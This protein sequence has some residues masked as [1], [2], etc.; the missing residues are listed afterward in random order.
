MQLKGG[1]TPADSMDM[2]APRAPRPS[3]RCIPVPV[4]ALL[5]ATIA[6]LGVTSTTAAAQQAPA[7][8][9]SLEE[10]L[11]VR[12]VAAA[13]REQ[14][15]FDSPRSISVVTADDLRRRNYRSTPEAL[16]EVAGVM[17]QQTN[18]GGGSPI[19]RGLIG[20][21]VLLMID[22]VRLNNAIYRLGPNQYL[23]TIDINSIERI[24]VIRGPGSVLFGSDALG[25][26]I[27]IVTKS[28]VIGD[29][30]PGGVEVSTRL[31]SAD[32]GAIGRVAFDGGTRRLSVVGG[33]SVA[34]L[35]QI[36]RGGG[37]VQPF[38]GYDQWAADVKL[39]VAAGAD[40]T[41]TLSAQHVNQSGIQ[42]TD[43]LAAGTDLEYRWDPQVR[44]LLSAEWARA[45]PL[46]FVRDARVLASYQEQGEH[47]FRVTAAR[48]S[49]RRQ[50]Y[51]GDRSLNVRAQLFSQKA[52]HS[53]TY[54][55]D[56]SEDWVRS[57]RTDTVLATGAQTLQRGTYADGGRASSV[58]AFLQD[59]L[60]LTR[61]IGL[62]LGAR[63]TSLNLGAALADPTTGSV[64]VDTHNSG[65]VGSTYGTYLLT[66]TLKV[67]GGVSQGFR[68]PNIDDVSIL[69][70]FGGGFEV[71]NPTL[72]P[73]RSL[74]QV[75]GLK[76]SQRRV[77]GAVSVF[78]VRYRD[79]I[80]RA[81]G[82]FAG[83][84]FL[85]LN[86]N[87][88]REAVEPLVFKRVN[89]GRANVKGL[90]VDGRLRVGNAWAFGG[91]VSWT[92]GEDVSAGEPLRRIPPVHGTVRVRF[93]PGS[94]W[95]VE[96]YS[97]FSEDQRRLNSGDVSDIRIGPN[98]TPGFVTLSARAG[99][100]VAWLGA[101][102]VGLDNVGDARYKWHGSGVERPGRQVVVGVR[103]RF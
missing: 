42:R 100:A 76:L 22:G 90:E 39:V 36:R 6:L 32:R 17:V 8:D 56:L 30:H 24:E 92:S 38:T 41:V 35:G 71:P 74:N 84:S 59:Q 85:D 75:V 62:E 9:M 80:A 69:G 5:V 70:S 60:T 26:I 102:T 11:N 55:A 77:I 37:A 87:G 88:T 78:N 4:T 94:R 45:K 99:V 49:Q 47:I 53:L 66:D 1:V 52:G 83:R 86:G 14:R 12:V 16:E 3:P 28:R 79:L 72:S 97:L 91:N 68:A 34:S 64:A 27:N 25:G 101:I 29:A 82:E 2:L 21:Q 18:D 13:S 89:I 20:N 96:A 44:T 103:R 98:G 65:L 43:V 19:L 54:G 51:D 73:E 95:W 63:Y 33:V 23:N 61:R 7:F 48:P 58:A 57:T 10:L 81:P 67:V 15:P 50:I 46:G 31:S 93:E 40:Q